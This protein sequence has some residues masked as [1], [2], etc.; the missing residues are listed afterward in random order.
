MQR[1]SDK[2][3][4]YVV[5]AGDCL[6]LNSH[7]PIPTSPHHL[8]KL[9][10]DPDTDNLGTFFFVLASD[11]HQEGQ[12]ISVVMF[13][14]RKLH[15]KAIICTLLEVFLTMSYTMTLWPFHTVTVSGV[16][17]TPLNA[18][19]LSRGQI[20]E[21]NPDKSLKSFPPPVNSSANA[22]DFY[23]FNLTQPLTVS[24]KEKGEKPDR[25]PYPLPY[26]S[27]NPYRNLKTD[28]TQDYAQKPQRDCTVRSWIR[29]REV[30]QIY[31]VYS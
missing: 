31:L 4:V 10:T 14:L 1:V 6:I 29:S 3:A 19:L 12:F 21:R 11:S 28:N 2:G 17:N 30:D 9:Y 13:V 16:T 23:F 7:N 25:K 8:Y 24:V 27:R 18:C 22:W 5:L 20:L 26:G 15:W